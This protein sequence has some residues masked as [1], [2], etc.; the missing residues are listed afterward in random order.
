MAYS[1]FLTDIPAR[2]LGVGPGDDVGY[3]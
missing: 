3:V 2:E 1:S